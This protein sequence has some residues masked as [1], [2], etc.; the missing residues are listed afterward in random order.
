MPAPYSRGVAP[1][2]SVAQYASAD[3]P[4]ASPDDTADALRRSL[5][6]HGFADAEN[7]FVVGTDG[8]FEGVLPLGVLLGARGDAAAVTLID[9]EWPVVPPG[10]SRE[11][12]AS[13]AIR[14]D[15]P[16]LP[17]CDEGGRFLGAVP[18]RA[19]IGILRDEHLEDLH[20]MAGILAQGA[21]AQAALTAS[22]WRRALYRLPWLLAGVIGA[23]VA[24]GLMARFEAALKAQIALA[25]FVPAIVY[26]A[27]AV[28]TQSEAVAVR[29]LSLTDAGL[30]DVLASEVATGVLIGMALAAGTFPLVWL[31]FGSAPLAATV[32]LSLAVAAS[33]ATGLGFL[34]PWLFARLGYDPALGSG[35][36]AT[37]IQ[38]VISIA[39]YFAFAW[40][41]L[42]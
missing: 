29:G 3:V 9:R 42:L 18:A 26:L 38:D 28:G 32:A 16:A 34:L 41:I 21:A 27:D 23:A 11:D 12:A 40:A 25:F 6:G 1:A 5:E 15:V 14:R 19:L 20:H 4:T 17:V 10:M 13:V 35:P 39:I 7:V 33:V 37:V 36:V 22:P 31:A 8:R 2:Q 24:T 30:R